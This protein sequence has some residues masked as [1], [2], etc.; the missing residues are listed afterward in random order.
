VEGY[1]FL[2]GVLLADLLYFLDLAVIL[3]LP[4]YY[5]FLQAGV[6]LALL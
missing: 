3:L 4:E 1:W 2:V 5:Q 6:L